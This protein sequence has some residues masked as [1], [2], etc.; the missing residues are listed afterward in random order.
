MERI[1]E[2]Y[3]EKLKEALPKN[4]IWKCSYAIKEKLKE[5][6]SGKVISGIIE[7]IGE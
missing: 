5:R 1:E 6:A 3:W 2:K 4:F 7:I